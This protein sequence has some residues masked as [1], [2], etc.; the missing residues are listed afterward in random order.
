M[1]G[2]IETMSTVL[3]SVALISALAVFGI[4]TLIVREVLPHLGE[5]EQ[6]GLRDWLRNYSTARFD[7]ALRNVWNLHVQFFPK[8]RKRT[9][10]GCLF[11]AACISVVAIPLFK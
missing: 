4:M 5:D 7:R 2:R 6:I 11:T 9:L 1:T 10:L 8:S 3:L